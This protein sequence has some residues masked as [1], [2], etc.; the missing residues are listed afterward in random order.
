MPL[1][2]R[3]DD[4]SRENFMSRCMSN[5]DSK[6]EFP[7]NKQRVAVC[8]TK[9]TEGMS[10]M[11]AADLNYNVEEFG[12]TE[13]LTEENFY[14][15]TEAEYD[16]VEG[17]STQ[18]WDISVARPGLWENIR[19]KKEREGKN[20]RPARTEKERSQNMSAMPIMQKQTSP[21]QKI[22]EGL[23]LLKKIR[24]E[25]LKGTSQIAQKIQAVKLLLVKRL[26]KDYLKKL[27]NIMLKVKVQKQL[28]ACLKQF[29]EGVLEPIQQAM[30]QRCQEMDGLWLELMLF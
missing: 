2:K 4:E 20:Y 29:T 26:L 12:Y 17:E 11:A 9:A 21:D 5:K 18:D 25:D 19:R 10:S 14:I 28:L 7:D 15:P 30:R 27:E 23:P 13:E 3:R 24:K 16:A 6:K 22:R 1:P 8:L